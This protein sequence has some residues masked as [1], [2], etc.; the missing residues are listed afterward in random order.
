M[1]SKPLWPILLLT[2]MLPATA[3]S[4][5]VSKGQS[6]YQQ[7]CAMCH[8]RTGKGSMAGTPDFKRREG[9]LQ[10]DQSLLERVKAGKNACPAYQGILTDQK[11]YDVIA[12]LRTLSL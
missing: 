4:S 3:Q 2:L 8:G 1:H 6:V 11:I 10:S 12:Y 5:D 7:R 9:L